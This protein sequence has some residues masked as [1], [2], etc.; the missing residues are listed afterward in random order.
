MTTGQFWIAIFVFANIFISMGIMIFFQHRRLE[1]LEGY[2]KGVKGVEQHRAVWGDGY[3]GRQMRLSNVANIVVWPRLYHKLG[4]IPQG[5]NQR[6]P[7]KLRKQ[8]IVIY[9]HLII[10]VVAMVVLY[11]MLPDKSGG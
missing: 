5:A 6:I 7:E 11:F 4:E 1:M 8:L 10:S 3:I 2:L 9:S